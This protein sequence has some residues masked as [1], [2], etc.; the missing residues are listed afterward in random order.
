VFSEPASHRAVQVKAARAVLRD[1]TAQDEPV[2]ACYLASMEHEIQRVGHPPAVTRAMLAHRIEDL[3]AITF[4][5]QQA[6]NQTPGA[7][8]GAV[9]PAGTT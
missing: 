3:V 7:K 9:L 5:P 6:F 1:A 8:A 2:L 4:E